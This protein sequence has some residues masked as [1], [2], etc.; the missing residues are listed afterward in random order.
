MPVLILH[1]LLKQKIESLIYLD[2]SL[3]LTNFCK[4]FKCIH[5]FLQW[6]LSLL[7]PLPDKPKAVNR[8]S[9]P[10]KTNVLTPSELAPISGYTLRTSLAIL[11]CGISVGCSSNKFMDGIETTDASIPSSA[12]TFALHRQE[13]LQT[14]P[15]KYFSICTTIPHATP[16]YN[17]VS[18][19]ELASL[20]WIR[21][22]FLIQQILHY[23]QQD[24]SHLSLGKWRNAANCSIGSCGPSSPN[25]NWV[26]CIHIDCW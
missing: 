6:S 8:H 26:M 20:T 4:R 21:S 18:A 13:P 11:I 24:E 19:L 5:Y 14:L 10:I 7:F 22:F 9:C 23:R 16:S 15:T 3:I 2:Q 17:S 12:R 1:I 25:C